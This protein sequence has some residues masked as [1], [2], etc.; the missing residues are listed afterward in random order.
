MLSI[1]FS[2][3]PLLTFNGSTQ[4]FNVTPCPSRAKMLSTIEN[5]DVGQHSLGTCDLQVTLVQLKQRLYL[6]EE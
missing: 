3:S 5:G 6:Q 1:L 4:M 2:F